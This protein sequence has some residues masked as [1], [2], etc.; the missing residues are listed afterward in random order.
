MSELEVGSDITDSAERAKLHRMLS[1]FLITITDQVFQDRDIYLDGYR[2]INCSF[3]RCRVYVHR[4][5]FELHHC[6]IGG[7]T[8]ILDQDALKS[9]QF[10]ALATPNLEHSAGF[11]AQKN[12]DGTISIG[13]GATIQ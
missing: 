12:S 1:E 7:G 11:S 13:K 6:L 4:G 10:Y 9:V 5:T 3:V 8:S 2:F